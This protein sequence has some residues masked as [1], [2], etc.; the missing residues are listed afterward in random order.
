MENNLFQFIAYDQYKKRFIETFN[1]FSYN[2]ER[3]S[4]NSNKKFVDI[5][6]LKGSKDTSEYWLAAFI[7]LMPFIGELCIIT[8]DNNERPFIVKSENMEKFIEFYND[9]L[10]CFFDGDLIII[11]FE[12]KYF[13]LKH[14]EDTYTFI[15]YNRID[16]YP[17][18]NYVYEFNP[19]FDIYNL[20]KI[21]VNI[22]L[23]AGFK[24][25]KKYSK[26]VDKEV[27]VKILGIGS[28]LMAEIIFKEKQ[29]SDISKN[30]SKN[31]FE[32]LEYKL[33]ELCI[34]HINS[35]ILDCDKTIS[36]S[37]VSLSRLYLWDKNNE[38]QDFTTIGDA[39]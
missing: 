32:T 15:D 9:N 13:W 11:N 38:S 26:I 30:I 2:P 1:F 10:G 5:P 39:F 29:I 7:N 4:V 20:S 3:F 37:N 6:W 33:L 23:K 31:W 17:L 16:D 21:A 24:F 22:N 14:H 19:K 27:Y 35:T 12:K 18:N 8:F 34:N 36:L 25:D 28:I